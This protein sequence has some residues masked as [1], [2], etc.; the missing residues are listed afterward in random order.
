MPM[1]G[2]YRL[3]MKLHAF[4]IQRFMPDAHDFIE[5]A[6]VILRPCGDFE[7]I[8]QVFLFDDEGMVTGCGKRVIQAF[9]DANIIV[10]N[11]RSLAVHD[12]FGM[13]DMAAKGIAYALMTK[14][15][16]QDRSVSCKL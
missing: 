10:V 1:L 8:R 15:N 7:A 14:A 3:G 2:Q 9:E 16:T 6:R 13:N 5:P 12:A 4:Y 11:Q